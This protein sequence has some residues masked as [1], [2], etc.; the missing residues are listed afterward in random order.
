MEGSQLKKE[1]K[2][3]TRD[4]DKVRRLYQMK[5]REYD[6]TD[7]WIKK[8]FHNPKFKDLKKLQKYLMKHFPYF[9]KTNDHLR[10]LSLR[11]RKA[12]TI[13][14]Y[15]NIG[16][17][18]KYRDSPEDCIPT[19]SDD[20]LCSSPLFEEKCS[21]ISFN[22]NQKD[23]TTDSQ[24][25]GDKSIGVDQI[26]N[27][28][29]SNTGLDD[30]GQI[31]NEIN[32]MKNTAETTENEPINNNSPNEEHEPIDSIDIDDLFMDEEADDEFG[33][34]LYE[35]NNEHFSSNSPEQYIFLYC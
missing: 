28:S 32:M 13:W 20:G 12:M 16:W 30:G 6:D 29:M 21:P 18:F 23:L 35:R 15:E 8:I 11:H 19:S 10:R 27:I 1:T 14:I 4:K 7:K 2:Q 24:R 3:T 22:S 17:F 25:T 26:T 33:W 9:N 34:D 31:F 5:E